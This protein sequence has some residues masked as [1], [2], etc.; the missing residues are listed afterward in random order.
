VRE[1]STAA[2]VSR[3]GLIGLLAVAACLASASEDKRRQDSSGCSGRPSVACTEIGC[4]DGLIVELRPGSG[5]LAGDYR[6]QIR[7]DRFEVACRGS[8]PLASC[9][10]SRAPATRASVTCDIEGP[11]QIAESGC[12]LPVSAHGFPEL[13][14]DPKIRPAR[15]DIRITKDGQV[16]GQGH[17]VPSFERIHPNGPECPPAC[18]VAHAVVDVHF[19][20]PLHPD[21]KI[22]SSS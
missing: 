16:V 13:M 15:V 9:A 1:R 18:D 6:F 12:A 3:A 10:G 8:L 2:S 19:V 22:S 11:V 21:E 7:T 14:F 17:F 4:R 5:W 20:G